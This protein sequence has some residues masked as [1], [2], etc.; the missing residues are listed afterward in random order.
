M[1]K[2]VCFDSVDMLKIML[3][4]QYFFSIY[5]YVIIAGVSFSFHIPESFYRN[6]F[7]SSD[8]KMS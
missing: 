5:E 8:V 7:G 1:K 6:W 4:L 2:R 3:S